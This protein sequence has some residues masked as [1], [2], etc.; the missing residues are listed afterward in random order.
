M[1]ALSLAPRNERSPRFALPPALAVA[2]AGKVAG[3]ALW[4]LHARAAGAAL[5]FGPDPFVLHAVFAPSAQGLGRV[6]TRFVTERREIWLTIDDGPDPDDTPRILDL[7]ERHR[8]RATFFLVGTRA[9][10]WPELV[11]EILRR[12]HEVAH[13]THTHPVATWWCAGPVRLAA[14]LDLGTAALRHGGAT[15]RRFRPPVGIKHLLLDAALQRRGLDCIGWTIRSGDCLARDAD[16]VVRSVMRRLRPGA[17]VLLHE[18]PS[19]PAPLRVTTIARVLEAL[20]ERGFAC[21][22][23]E[24]AALR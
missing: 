2:I 11:A 4:L 1:P 12:G 10:R 13:H 7:L 9:A 5:F 6:F 19:L 3:V 16:D 17:I 8:A 24:R 21:V 22:I 23:P 20:A 14:E 15:P 18:G